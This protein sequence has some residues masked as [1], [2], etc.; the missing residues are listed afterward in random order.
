MKFL[1]RTAKLDRVSPASSYARSG[2]GRF[3]QPS[4]GR[5]AVA[6]Y[7]SPAFPAAIQPDGNHPHNYFAGDP[8]R[9]S[10]P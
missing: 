8:P 9:G 4:E 6:Q 3:A 7:G 5:F 10:G 2:Y 1:S